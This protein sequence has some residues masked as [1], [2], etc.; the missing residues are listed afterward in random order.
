MAVRV[1]QGLEVST[2]WMWREMGAL[3]GGPQYTTHAIDREQG[4]LGVTAGA[5]P[6]PLH[7]YRD[8]ARPGKTSG[9]SQLSGIHSGEVKGFRSPAS[10]NITGAGTNGPWLS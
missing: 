10:Y 1:Q 5:S 7:W 4:R 8:K 9:P 6:S 3:H 2:G